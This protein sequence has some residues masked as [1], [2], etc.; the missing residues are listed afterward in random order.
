MRAWIKAAG[1][2]AIKTFCQSLIAMIPAGIVITEVDWTLV[3]GTSLLA[4]VLS[5]ITSVAGLPELE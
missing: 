3:L 4:A 1:I 5:L 2:R